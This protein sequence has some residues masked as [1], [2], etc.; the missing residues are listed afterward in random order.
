MSKTL[1]FVLLFLIIGTYAEAQSFYAVRRERSL[2]LTGGVGTSSYFGELTNPGDYLNA[3]PALN[4]GLQYYISNRISIRAEANWF[5][6][7]GDDAKAPVETGRQPRN[8]SF[9]SDN[10]EA[11]FTGHFS[12]FPQGRRFYQR[13]AVNLYGF[14]GIGILFFNPK[15]EYQGETYS[16]Q[17]LQTE[18]VKYNRF[19]FVVPFGVGAKLKMGPFFNLAFEGGYRIT[20]TDYLDDVSTVHVDR[21]KFT[22]PIAAILS[23]RGPE[24][25]YAPALE[26]SIRGNPKTNDGYFLFSAKIEYY[27]P[28]DFI[29]GGGNPQKKLSKQRNNAFKRY[30][31]KGRLK[32]RR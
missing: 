9:K 28:H 32:R 10:F 21:T 17:P 14:G 30:S 2:I 23:D 24:V 22:D 7:K 16:L 18:L 26:G 19:G 27:L 6:I 5:Q 11:N 1:Q 12:F 20:F 31:K 15:A 8:L 25:N 29:F 4:T 3:K 13:P